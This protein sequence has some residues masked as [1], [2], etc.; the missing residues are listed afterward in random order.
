MNEIKRRVLLIDER[1]DAHLR[2]ALADSGG[3][4]SSCNSPKDAWD[5]IYPVPPHFI[6]VRLYH[7]NTEDVTMLQECRFMAKG[8]PIVVATTY[9][10]TEVL[11]DVLEDRPAAFLLLP[12][13][14]DDVIRVFS[15]V[16]QSANQK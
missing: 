14:R 2:A 1:G 3:K 9:E 16:E 10:Q 8:A 13:G 4:L 7:P 11:K 15:E 5:L 12:A 6:V